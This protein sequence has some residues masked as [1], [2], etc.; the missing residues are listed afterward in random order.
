MKSKETVF[1]LGSETELLEHKKSTG[2][3]KE[4]VISACAMLNKH[5]EGTVFFWYEE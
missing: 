5:G 4:G 3:L 2:E 1:N